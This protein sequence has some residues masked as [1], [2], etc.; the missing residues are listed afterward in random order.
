[1]ENRIVWPGQFNEVD[2]IGSLF[3][4]KEKRRGYLGHSS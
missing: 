1:M 3:L 4:E 2:K